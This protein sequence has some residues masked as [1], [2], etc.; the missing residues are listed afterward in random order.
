MKFLKKIILLICIS[1]VFVTCKKEVLTPSST[2]GQPVFS[3][4]GTIGTNSLNLQA[5]VN[6]YYMYS[7]YNQ[8]PAG[9]NLVVY[10]FTGNLQNTGTPN[11]SISITLN[12]YRL[13][14]YNASVASH[15]DSCITPAAY[16]YNIPGGNPIWDSVTFKP[17][18][19]DGQPSSYTYNFGD[20]STTTALNESPVPHIYK[21][22][23]NYTP[24][25]SAITNNGNPTV[26]K[27]LNLT[28]QVASNPLIIDSVSYTDSSYPYH[29]VS[30]K[31]Y[32][33]GSP[34]GYVWIFGDG[35]TVLSTYASTSH[36]YTAVVAHTYSVTVGVID[37][38]RDT[39][40][41]D[42]TLV[43][44]NL[45]SPPCRIN[46]FTT[47]KPAP[48]PL[49]LS[50]VTVNYTDGKG[51]QYTSNNALQPNSSTFQVTSVSGYQNNMYNQPT[52]ML[53]VKFNCTLYPLLGGTPISATN[54]IATIA[55]AYQ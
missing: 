10:S 24:T 7:S 47:I 35:D 8:N 21:I 46:Y 9:I 20:G 5:G 42:F 38:S 52:E 45:S 53:T 34:V 23:K 40:R 37:Q 3:F 36:S 2:V 54:C 1:A 32:T 49:S 18:V 15:L 41:Y 25:L 39:A 28:K 51:N 29:T 17:L 22:L 14:S 55:V 12:D 16:Y 30:F 31:A 44:S 11:N 4:T 48:N 27:S 50:N 6:N 43:D 19:H 13:S 26:S 33:T